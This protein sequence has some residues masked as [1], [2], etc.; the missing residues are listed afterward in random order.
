LEELARENGVDYDILMGSANMGQWCTQ[1]N[2]HFFLLFYACILRFYL[3]KPL[4]SLSCSLNAVFPG[5]KMWD[6]FSCT[7]ANVLT[8]FIISIA[9]LD[10]V[11]PDAGLQKRATFSTL[12]VGLARTGNQTRA[13]CVACCGT[14][15]SAIHYAFKHINL[16]CF[17]YFSCTQVERSKC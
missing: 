15:R 6:T 5:L 12:N 1:P 3:L 9:V 13:T 11:P 2:K 17:L 7:T 14:N 4:K 16:Q 10:N 8:H